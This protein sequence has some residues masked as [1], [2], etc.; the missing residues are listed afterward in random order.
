[1]PALVAVLLTFALQLLVGLGIGFLSYTVAMPALSGFIQDYFTAL[2]PEIL[3]ILGLL[4]V[5][6]AMSMMLSALAANA[7]TKLIPTKSR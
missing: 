5:D 3:Q 4:K 6:I 2:P 7:S 1:M